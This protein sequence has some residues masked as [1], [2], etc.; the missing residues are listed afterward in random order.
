MDECRNEEPR[1]LH[2]LAVLEGGLG[3]T[4]RPSPSVYLGT[5]QMTTESEPT[6]ASVP[7]MD[8]SALSFDHVSMVYP[9]GTAALSD[10]TLSVRPGEF[11]SIVGPSGCG[12]STLLRIASGIITASAGT[13]S[14]E[15][16]RLGFVFQDATLLPWRTVLSNAEL[17]LELHGVPSD[18][19][20]RR[21]LEAITA[22]GL[23]GFEMYHP[24]RLSGGMKM[25]ASLA[26]WLALEPTLF[27]FDEPFGALDEITRD[28][29]NDELLSLFYEKRFS[30]VFVTHSVFEAVFVSSRVLV[31]SGRPG[32][33][34]TEIEV[35][36]GYPRSEKLRF[37]GAV[38]EIAG[39]VSAALRGA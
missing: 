30:A 31:M 7:A 14:V 25:R 6:N 32:R 5:E 36:F 26:R 9:D 8:E 4:V 23:E 16:D 34:V 35:P 28:R 29:L 15:A 17:L 24:K 21:A 22:V 13:V 19:R 3:Q 12:K 33:I 38:S 27:L 37:D 2:D 39:Q 1:A 11:T 18:E 20:R 10:V